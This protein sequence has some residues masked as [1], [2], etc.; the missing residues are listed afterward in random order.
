VNPFDLLKEGW[1][2]LLSRLIFDLEAPFARVER[3]SNR[4]NLNLLQAIV[5]SCCPT[6]LQ[7]EHAADMPFVHQPTI[8][9]WAKIS[10]N[11][12]TNQEVRPFI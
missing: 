7:H 11:A 8:T 6:I 4:L 12:I 9:A 2:G 10:L 5:G 3:V 1:E